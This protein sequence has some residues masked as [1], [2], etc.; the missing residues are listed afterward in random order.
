MTDRRYTL[1]K[2]ERL[3]RKRDIDLLFAEGQSFIAY[4]LRVVYTVIE[5]QRSVPA[6][7]LISVSKKKFK[8]AVKR[9]A[10]KRQIRESYRI[11]K[12][13]LFEPLQTTGRYLAIAFIFLE[14]EL[15]SNETMEKAMEKAIRLLGEKIQ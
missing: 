12:Q 1:S 10:V 9:N 8:R 13:A 4:P 7:I 5:E 3:S 14:K 6:S 15:A 11:R 2:A